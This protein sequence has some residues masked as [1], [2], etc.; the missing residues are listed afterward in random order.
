MKR[1]LFEKLSGFDENIFMYMD[2]IDLL[3][4]AKK[5]GY[6]TY[7]TPDVE[8]VHLASASSSKRTFPI[9]QVYCGLLY[10]YKKHHSTLKLQI[11]KGMLQ[12]K[13][14]IAYFIGTITQNNYLMKT[15]A[16]AQKMVDMA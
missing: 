2:E 16:E 14:H 11:L 1:A 5:K 3:Y 6:I 7:V 12:L 10:F 9:L 15:Y 13:A 8:I 4:R